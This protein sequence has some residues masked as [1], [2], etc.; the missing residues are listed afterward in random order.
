MQ[1]EFPSIDFATQAEAR[2]EA[3]HRRTE[4]V[5]GLLRG[6]FGE[7]LAKFRRLERPVLQ[8]VPHS[9]RTAKAG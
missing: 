4:E 9:H 6:L 1:R 8:T 3:E 2:L 7:W 5:T